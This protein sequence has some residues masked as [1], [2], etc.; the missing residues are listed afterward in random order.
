MKVQSYDNRDE[1]I[2]IN[3][4]LRVYESIED[5]ISSRENPTPLV[6]LNNRINPNKNFPIY[7]KLERYNPFGSIKD[8]IAYSMLKNFNNKDGQSI[9]EPSSGNTGIALASLANARGI[10]VEIAVPSRIPEEKKI[11]LKLLGVKELWEADDN[12]CPK[13][14]N[15]GARGVV[16]GILTSKGGERYFNPNQ[17]ENFLNVQAHYMST[18]PEIWEQTNGEVDYFFAATGTCGTITGVGKYL[19]EKKPSVKILGVEPSDTLHNIPGLKKITDL[20]KDL[21]PKILDETVIDKIFEV[22][23]DDAYKTGIEIARKNGILVGP[24]TGAILA[25]ALDFARNNEGLAVIIAPD[26]ANKYIS[27]Y[28]PY[29]NGGEP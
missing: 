19:K 16:N 3:N 20:D 13:F 17:Y 2:G 12:L 7:M 28:T 26:D 23:D 21:I 29:I 11:L 14:P 10:P 15:E 9:L 4:K 25:A 27:S 8:R 1:K 5:L 22:S 24:S 6:K 18:G